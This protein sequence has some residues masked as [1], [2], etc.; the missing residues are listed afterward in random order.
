M[1]EFIRRMDE[2]IYDE[3]EFKKALK[4]T[5]E[6]CKEGKDYNSPKTQPLAARNG[7]RM[8]NSP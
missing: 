4:W 5:K 8:G 2:G 7:L 6:N 3:A 1:T